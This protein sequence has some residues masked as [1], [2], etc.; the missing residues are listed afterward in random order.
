[1]GYQNVALKRRAWL[2]TI[3]GLGGGLGFV[4]AGQRSKIGQVLVAW[5]YWLSI[6]A[7]ELRSK[8]GHAF[9]PTGRAVGFILAKVRP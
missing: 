9:E 8:K 7:S 1:M 6:V 3:L 4:Q 2:L 5:I